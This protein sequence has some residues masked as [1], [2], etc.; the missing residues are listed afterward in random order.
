MS[1]IYSYFRKLY[2]TRSVHLRTCHSILWVA[3][4]FPIS[5][6]MQYTIG[7]E[8]DGKTILWE[9]YEYHFPRF[10]PYSG[11]CCIFPCYGKLMGKP[12]HFPYTELYQRIGIRWEKAPILWG[13]YEYQFPMFFPYSEFCCIFTC[14]GKLMGK[15]KHFPYAEV[16]H[17][18]RM[19]KVWIPISQVVPIHW[20]LLHFPVIWK[21]DG[22][23]HAFPIWWNSLVFACV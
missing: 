9:K 8:S 16:F 3:K 17:R 1:L 20:V 14:Y 4:N 21:V 15:P 6:M 2:I 5:H 23:A 19:G 18:I 12:M 11:L 13:K 22:K 10:S 7:W